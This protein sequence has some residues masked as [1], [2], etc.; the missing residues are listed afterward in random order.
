MA[1][2]F[3]V[4]KKQKN[5]NSLDLK[6][7]GDFDASSA[8]ELHNLLSTDVGKTSK[9]AIDTSG[10]KTV[11]PFGIDLFLPLMSD[12]HHQRMNIE[13]TG[14]FSRAFREE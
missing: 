4:S 8:Y 12:L 1:K 5:K 3:R 6:L 11:S 7:F 13:V 9:V 2:N 10:L 14:R